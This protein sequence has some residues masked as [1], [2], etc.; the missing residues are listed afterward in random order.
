MSKECENPETKK[1]GGACYNC[2]EEG[3]IIKECPQPRDDERIKK[4]YEDRDANVPKSEMKEVIDFRSGVIDEVTI[5]YADLTSLRLQGIIHLD[6]YDHLRVIPSS[7]LSD[8][9][10]VISVFKSILRKVK[11]KPN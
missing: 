11:G 6:N 1:H 3:H 5:H 4:A 2:G 10:Y 7:C 8:A 9:H